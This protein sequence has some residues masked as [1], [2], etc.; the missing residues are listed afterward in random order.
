M[1]LGQRMHLYNR[2]S[3][4]LHEHWDIEYVYAGVNLKC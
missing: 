1:L 2:E 3:K 4:C